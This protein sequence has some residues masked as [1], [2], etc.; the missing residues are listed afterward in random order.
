MKVFERISGNM[1]RDNIS[2]LCTNMS[3]TH[4]M[5]L[6]KNILGWCQRLFSSLARSNFSDRGQVRF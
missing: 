3:G 1:R 4:E 6:Q 2:N 5:N